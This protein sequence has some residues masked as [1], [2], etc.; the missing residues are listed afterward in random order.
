MSV[1]KAAESVIKKRHPVCAS[2]RYNER[3]WRTFSARQF[4]EARLNNSKRYLITSLRLTIIKDSLVSFEAG[5]IEF[6]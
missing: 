5:K 1:F 2:D 6:S 3:T 4:E